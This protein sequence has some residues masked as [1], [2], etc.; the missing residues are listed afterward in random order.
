MRYPS[1]YK[2]RLL[3]GETPEQ[4]TDDNIAALPPCHRRSIRQSGALPPKD[5]QNYRYINTSGLFS[6]DTAADA[7]YCAGGR[8]GLDISELS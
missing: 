7:A 1:R 8:L 6:G 4:I 5:V 3:A 2:H